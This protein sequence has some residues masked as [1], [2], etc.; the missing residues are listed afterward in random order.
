MAEA[1]Q[2]AGWATEGWQ[3]VVKN[4]CAVMFESRPVRN[5]FR[6]EQEQRDCFDDV[7]HIVKIPAD[8]TLRVIVP[9]TAEHK[10]E[11]P[12]EWA[13]YQKTGETKVLGT[14]ID[15]WH[16]ITAGQK[17]EF[18][19][20]G[21]FTVEQFAN[22]PDSSAGKIMDFQNLRARAK[23]FTAS[24]KDAELVA[25]LKRAK[26]ESDKKFEELQ[27]QFNEMKSLLEAKTKP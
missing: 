11:F 25:Q 3:E 17:L 8:Q 24:G 5:N 9:A 18:K 27:K 15:M 21:I 10:K 2:E 1:F 7:V 26:D 22:L 12:Q 4:R 14:P 13:A 6:S 19:A 16:G 23:A 20:M